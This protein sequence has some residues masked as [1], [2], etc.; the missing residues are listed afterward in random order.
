MIDPVQEAR[1]LMDKHFGLGIKE[2]HDFLRTNVIAKRMYDCAINALTELLSKSSDL[3]RQDKLSIV[4]KSIKTQPYSPHA[5]D[6]KKDNRFNE[7]IVSSLSDFVESTWISADREDLFEH[8][9]I[10]VLDALDQNQEIILPAKTQLLVFQMIELAK[11]MKDFDLTGDVSLHSWLDDG[12]DHN[13]SLNFLLNQSDV[14]SQAKGLVYE[15]LKF[16][17][18]TRAGAYLIFESLSKE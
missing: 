3:D 2:A 13:E 18:N 9:A 1:I 16:D 17:E 10:R 14:S 5:Y 6:S 4:I 7:E 11:K 12:N 15:A 8:V